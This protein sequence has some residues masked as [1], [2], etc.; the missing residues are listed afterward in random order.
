M[1]NV[2]MS[3]VLQSAEDKK[4]Q[5]GLAGCAEEMQDAQIIGQR[6]QRVN[7][8]KEARI[9]LCTLFHS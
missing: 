8:K 6:A 1:V 3:N 9:S 4:F 5:A 7:E 2:R